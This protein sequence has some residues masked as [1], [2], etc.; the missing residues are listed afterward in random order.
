MRSG[1]ASEKKAK[2]PA[3]FSCSPQHCGEDSLAGKLITVLPPYRASEAPWQVLLLGLLAPPALFLTVPLLWSCKP[4]QSSHIEL[5]SSARHTRT[6]LVPDPPP[7]VPQLFESTWCSSLIFAWLM[8]TNYSGL[9]FDF[10]YEV[11]LDPPTLGWVSRGSLSWASTPLELPVTYVVYIFS[12]YLHR[13]HEGRAISYSLFNLQNLA[14]S[15]HIQV[16]KN[17]L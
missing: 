13:V 8:A 15:R 1:I 7:I 10:T 14:H 2:S 16:L 11:F 4:L 9:I 6:E 17:Y 3:P 5:R 12:I